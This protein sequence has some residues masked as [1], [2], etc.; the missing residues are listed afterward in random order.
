[1]ELLLTM[2]FL[3]G[4]LVLVAGGILASGVQ[5][6]GSGDLPQT[7]NARPK[8]QHQTPEEAREEARGAGGSLPTRAHRSP[9]FP[10]VENQP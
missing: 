7:Q 9:S 6:L 4:L 5:D 1:M 2:G 10:S 8:I 3:A